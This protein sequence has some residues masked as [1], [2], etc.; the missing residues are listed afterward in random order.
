M[1]RILPLCL[2]VLLSVPASHR[3]CVPATADDGRTAP[4]SETSAPAVNETDRKAVDSAMPDP[5]PQ[6]RLSRESSPYLLLHAHNPVDWYPWGAEAFDRARAENK[7]VFLSVGYSSCYWCHVMER[8]VF[9]N[10][11]IAE[12]LNQHFVCIK[13]DR[14]ERPDVD[15]IYMTSLIVYQQAAGIGGGGG[16]P[17]SLFLTPEGNPIAGA[18]YLPPD[19]TPDGRTGF[20]TA[21]GRVHS[22]WKENPDSV[23]RTASLIAGEVRRL[24]SPGVTL[25]SVD[26]QRALVNAATEDVRSHYDAVCGGVDFRPERPDGPRFPNVPRLQLL[27]CAHQYEPQPELLKIVRHSLTAMAEGGLRD[28]LGGGFHRYST[29]RRWHV[30][31]FE[32][33]LYD[34]A[35]LLEIYALAARETGDPLFA[36]VAGEIADFV[37]REMTLPD[38]GFCSALDAETNAIEGACYVWSPE[39]VAAVLGASDAPLFMQV[40]GMTRPNHFEHGFVLHLPDSLSRVAER[41]SLSEAELEARLQPLRARLLA[42]R[43]AR[44]KPLL[45]DK[46]LTEWNALMIQALAESGR[47]PG[48]ERDLRAAERAADFL[49]TQLRDAEGHLM[50][51]WRNGRSVYRAYLDDY[52]SLVSAL[53]RLHDATGSQKWLAAA[54][55]LN[56]QQIQLFFDSKQQMFFY[57][58][59]DHEQLIAR[60]STAYDSTFPSGNSVTVRN[61]LNLAVLSAASGVPFSDTASAEYPAMA[62]A[63]LQRFSSTLQKSPAACCGMAIAL[64]DWLNSSP[65]LQVA[66]ERQTP[67]RW[68][69]AGKPLLTAL[70]SAQ[71]ARP[72]GAGTDTQTVFKPVVPAAGTASPL[73]RDEKSERPVTAKV[74]PLFEKLERGGTCPVAVELTINPQWHINANPSKPDFLVPTE[75][76]V[77]SRQKIRLTRVKYPAHELLSFQG[78]DMPYHVYSG[79][80]LIYGLLETDAAETAAAGELE[81]RIRFQACNETTCI[82][83]DEVILKGKLPL[84]NPGDPIRRINEDKFPKPKEPTATPPAK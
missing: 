42:V 51:S 78:A 30:P 69:H 74:F 31:H 72:E 59:H 79:K 70:L 2:T 81:I 61:L 47:L 83:P 56:T 23:R 62:K 64:Q 44:P 17:L 58:S 21:A 45:D 37:A 54:Q 38:G 11:R 46:V 75:L 71:D 77:T 43:E 26:L 24:S 12:F 50:R 27:L 25:E 57:T 18:T 52:A 60:S 55:S 48:R 34:Q 19:D 39:E 13:V 68:H 53:L 22:I 49:L 32:K 65:K 1:M 73:T 29:D 28:H 5:A 9:S 10:A 14:E 8:E 35:Q 15:D 33:M 76:K 3:V 41:L 36:Q 66:E 84:A 7:P 67:P 4:P 6:N 16:W 80:I 82:A 20:L 40:Y 63:T